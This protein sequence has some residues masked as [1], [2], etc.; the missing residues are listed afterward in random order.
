MKSINQHTYISCD[1]SCRPK[2][3]AENKSQSWLCVRK[4]NRD[5]RRASDR[6]Q[7]R[8]GRSSAKSKTRRREEGEAAAPARKNQA[9]AHGSVRFDN[10]FSFCLVSKQWVELQDGNKGERSSPMAV[11]I[12]TSRKTSSVELPWRFPMKATSLSEAGTVRSAPP[13]RTRRW[14]QQ[15]ENCRLEENR[16]EKEDVLFY[17]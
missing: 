17:G 16:K 5:R 15:G 12:F 13:R 7:V 11:G 6:V 4:G 2:R 14:R 10:L 1:Y 3:I 8:K 9:K